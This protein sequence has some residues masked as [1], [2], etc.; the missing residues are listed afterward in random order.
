M[1]RR[2]SWASALGATLLAASVHF[3]TGLLLVFLGMLIER[4]K[5][6][7]RAAA[8]RIGIVRSLGRDVA[9]RGDALGRAEIRSATYRRTRWGG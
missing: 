8:T 7:R 2:T 4:R 9:A 6:Q 5:W 3:G 1:H